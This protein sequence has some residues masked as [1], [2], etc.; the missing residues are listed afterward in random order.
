[1]V[2]AVSTLKRLF[3]TKEHLS[4]INR[5][6]VMYTREES[7]SKGPVWRLI[8]AVIVPSIMA[9]IERNLLLN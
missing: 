7:T 9:S 3:I 5:C 2:K 6:Q 4:I 1:M 8:G